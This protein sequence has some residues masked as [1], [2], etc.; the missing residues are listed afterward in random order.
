MLFVVLT[1]VGAVMLHL[2]VIRINRNLMKDRKCEGNKGSLMKR[3]VKILDTKRYI[4]FYPFV[5]H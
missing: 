5:F 4:R 1:T 2:I 3:I